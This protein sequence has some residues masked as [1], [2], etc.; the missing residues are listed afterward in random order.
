[1]A[2]WRIKEI[3]DL[4]NVSVRMLHHYDKIGLLI[5]SM[6]TSNGYRWYSSLDLVKLQQIIALK[7]F[8]FSLS[9]IKTMLQQKLSIQDGLS[10][11]QRMLQGQVESLRLAL[12][13]LDIVLEKYKVSNSLDWKHLI[14]LIE[15]YRMAE[16][17]KNTWAGKLNE[18]QQERYL[19]F[20]EKYPREL[21]DWAS[22]IE[23]INGMQLGSPEGPEGERVVKTFLE[24]SKALIK[25]E[26]KNKSQKLTQSAASDLLKMVKELKAKG[27]PLSS[28]GS[29]WFAKAL[30]VHR[31]RCWDQLHKDIT[32]NMNAD[33]E[34]EAGKKLAKKWRDL[35]AEHDIGDSKDF[36]FGTM[37]LIESARGKVELQ[38]QITRPS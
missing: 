34:G 27:I 37:L 6:R 9:Q 8:G 30:I 2:K 12:D 7:F 5:P 29:I 4:T 10:A 24:F 38:N 35:V 11:Q 14:E 33:P 32:K 21:K 23:S 15:R 22:A 17:I 36:F 19:E 28:E 20:M 25:W 1:M 13:A 3:S 26:E 31:L 16:E 18:P